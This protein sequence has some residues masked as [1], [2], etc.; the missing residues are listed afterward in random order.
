MELLVGETLEARLRAGP[1]DSR[2][3]TEIAAQA[4][5][6]LAAAH[7]AGLVHRDIKPANLMLTRGGRVKLL[8]FGVAVA[9]SGRACA[10]GPG[11]KTRAL[12]GFAV[13]GTPEYMAPE[14]VAGETIDAR[15]DIYALGCVLHEMLSGA[16]PFEGSSG[17][18]VMGKQLRDAPR[19]PRVIAPERRIATALEAVVT[20]AMEKRPSR[21]FASAAAMREALEQTLRG[22]ERRRARA[23]GLASGVLL[24][25]ALLASAAASAQWTR[26]H[27]SSIH[28]PGAETSWL[29]PL[30]EPPSPSYADVEKSPPTLT[31]PTTP[32]ATSAPPT[33]TAEPRPAESPPHRDAHTLTKT[34]AKSRDVAGDAEPEPVLQ[35]RALLARSKR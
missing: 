34:L 10:A 35:R 16:P 13:F 2:Q 14:Q 21:R 22:P 26:T 31:A 8:D 29:R 32:T 5:E 6:A 27:L 9:L 18:V 30:A 23:R 11:A 17:V 19:S 7:A 12:Q 3:A 28:L 24:A 4:C 25:A 1:L 20:H 15:T 33:T